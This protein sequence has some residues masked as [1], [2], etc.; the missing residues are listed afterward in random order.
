YPNLLDTGP[1]GE[2]DAAGVA[3]VH[4]I[5]GLLGT[6][7]QTSQAGHLS[8]SRQFAGLGLRVAHVPIGSAS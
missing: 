3:R 8:A 5:A 7:V 4:F 6:T 2:S 1:V